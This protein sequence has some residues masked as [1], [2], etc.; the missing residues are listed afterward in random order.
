[1]KQLIHYMIFFVLS[2]GMLSA[3]K[4]DDPTPPVPPGPEMTLETGTIG[5]NTAELKLTNNG[6]TAYAYQVTNNLNA[7]APT[8]AILFGTGTSDSLKQG[9]NII[10][11]TGLEGNTDYLLHLATK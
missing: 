4:K 10:T 3:C 6:M 1:M 8:A 2:A 5:T 11:V 7:T 9:E